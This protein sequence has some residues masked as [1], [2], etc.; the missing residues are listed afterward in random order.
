MTKALGCLIAVFSWFT[1]MVVPRPSPTRTSMRA[2]KMVK[3]SIASVSPPRDSVCLSGTPLGRCASIKPRPWGLRRGKTR[4]FSPQ[5][6]ELRTTSFLG[7]VPHEMRSD[8]HMISRER[9]RAKRTPGASMVSVLSP[10]RCG[11]R[12]LDGGLGRRPPSKESTS[13][14]DKHGVRA[15]AVPRR[16]LLAGLGL[17]LGGGWSLH[18]WDR[19]SLWGAKGI[20][21]TASRVRVI[22]TRGLTRSAT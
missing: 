5:N 22:L 20:G 6:S 11:S 17:G 7:N 10:S 4:F 21:A 1:C 15:Q 9:A 8:F 16:S 12:A 2:S 13:R 14:N 18:R 19:K 3:A